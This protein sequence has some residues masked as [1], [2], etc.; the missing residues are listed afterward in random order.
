MHSFC[1][2]DGFKENKSYVN[3]GENKSKMTVAIL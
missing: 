3:L 2:Y 1:S